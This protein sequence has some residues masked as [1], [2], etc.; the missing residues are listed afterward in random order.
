MK[1]T[2]KLCISCFSGTQ[3]VF[4]A[5]R[6]EGGQG[7][8]PGPKRGRDRG[9]TG[10]ARAAL[11]ARAVPSVPCQVLCLVLSLQPLVFIESAL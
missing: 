9:H 10:A 7:T 5:T 6:E 11:R 8:G 2:P 3:G 4:I 1:T